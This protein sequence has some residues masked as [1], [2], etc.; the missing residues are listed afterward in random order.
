MF[1]KVDYNRAVTTED[2]TPLPLSPNSD[3]PSCQNQPTY[4]NQSKEL[5]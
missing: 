2:I 4:L 1:I 3:V 5:L